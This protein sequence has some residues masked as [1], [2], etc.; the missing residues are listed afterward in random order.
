MDHC[1]FLS[2]NALWAQEM[3]HQ[4]EVYQDDY[5]NDIIYPSYQLPAEN[6]LIASYATDIV[7]Y[8]KETFAQWVTGERDVDADWNNYLAHL[9]TLGVK[10]YVAAY[11]AYYDRVMK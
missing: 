8:V 10:E 9:E 6:E 5:I 1:T 11:Q 2:T 7:S 3:N 4:S